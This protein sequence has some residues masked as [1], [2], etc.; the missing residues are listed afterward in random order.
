M[1]YILVNLTD[2]PQVCHCI[3]MPLPAKSK[4]RVLTY[5]EVQ[6]IH[7]DENG[8]AWAHL[9]PVLLED[10]SPAKHEEKTEDAVASVAATEENVPVRGRRKTS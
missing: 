3:G 5:A 2:K 10:S 9:V 7:A 4:S 1:D 8:Y 6:A